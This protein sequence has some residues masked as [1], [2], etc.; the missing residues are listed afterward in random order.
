MSG[1]GRL[2]LRPVRLLASATVKRSLGK[3]VVSGALRSKVACTV[4]LLAC[5]AGAVGGGACVAAVLGGGVG[6]LLAALLA[7]TAATGGAAMAP[8]FPEAAR[9]PPIGPTPPEVPPVAY[10]MD[11]PPGPWPAPPEFGALPLMPSPA[12]GT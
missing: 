2:T 7:A 12:N 1:N 5:G 3:A 11:A 10:D 6:V 8:S 4:L 9:L